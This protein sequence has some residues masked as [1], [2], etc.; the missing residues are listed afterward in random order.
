MFN[1]VHML[2]NRYGLTGK[3]F[4]EAKQSKNDGYAKQEVIEGLFKSALEFRQVSEELCE[5][6]LMDAKT[7]LHPLLQQ[8]ELEKLGQ[9][10]EF[11]Q[12]FRHSLEGVVAE[13]IALWL[14]LVK[15][16]YRFDALRGRSTD[17]WDNR[18]HLLILVPRLLPSIN[19]L[20]AE[21]DREMLEQLQRFSWSRFQDSKSILEIQQ[22][23]PHEI[24][25]GVC[26]G[27][28]FYSLYTAPSQIWPLRS[29]QPD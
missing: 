3:Y 17:D 4:D 16:V 21:L 22:V 6:A 13:S 2:L 15:V 27:A 11:V 5:K 7:Q 26:Y 24:R 25:H 1:K 29:D 10:R 19:E 23:T 14:P 28:M 12:A 20:G 18:I 8:V 9:R